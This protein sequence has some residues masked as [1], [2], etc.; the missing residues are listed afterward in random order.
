[1]GAGRPGRD[2]RIAFVLAWSER[3]VRLVCALV[4]GGR[5]TWL[6]PTVVWGGRCA[7]RGGGRARPERRG[8]GPGDDDGRGRSHPRW[9]SGG[10]GE[11]RRSRSRRCRRSRGVRGSRP[12]WLWGVGV[13][14][15]AGR[16][17]TGR[18]AVR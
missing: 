2:A 18:A 3:T 14:A 16:G 11:M 5:G 10:L 1:M 17:W 6:A 8:G 15:V 4:S 7:G 13:P 9:V 12:R